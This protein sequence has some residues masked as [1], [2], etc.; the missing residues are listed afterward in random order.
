[1]EEINE[2]SPTPAPAPFETNLDVLSE[3]LY[4]HKLLKESEISKH[5]IAEEVIQDSQSK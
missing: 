3:N 4:I 5:Y 2:A 1:M